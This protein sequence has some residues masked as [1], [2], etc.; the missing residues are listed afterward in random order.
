MLTGSWYR[1]FMTE[2]SI[3][4]A[5]AHCPTC[6]GERTCNVHGTIR[7]NWQLEDEDNRFSVDGSV[8][9]SLLECRGCEKVFYETQSWDSESI[10]HYYNAQGETESKFEIRKATYPKPDT[11]TK[12]RW[13]DAIHKVDDQLHEILNEMYLAYDNDARI[14]TAIGLRTALDRSTELLKIDPAKT[15]KEKLDELQANGWIGETEKDILEVV[16]DAGGAAAHRGWKPGGPDI[17]MLLTVMEVF[18]QKAFIVGKDALSIKKNIPAKPKKVS[19]SK[20]KP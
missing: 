14:L 1:G 2:Q 18:L 9:H 3:N 4:T 17:A 11:K 10:D 19:G 16:T 13:F 12:P 6:D 20:P 5:R 8:D 7:K 15:F